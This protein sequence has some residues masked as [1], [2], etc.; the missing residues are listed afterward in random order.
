MQRLVAVVVAFIV[1]CAG[2]AQTQMMP[3]P[4]PTC[5]PGPIDQAS[6]SA[7]CAHGFSYDPAPV[8]YNSKETN[9]SQ[10][11]LGYKIKG[12]GQSCLPSKGEADACL[13]LLE[14]LPAQPAAKVVGFS[15]E[16][17]ECG[18]A[19]LPPKVSTVE[20]F[21]SN[22]WEASASFSEARTLKVGEVLNTLGVT[23]QCRRGGTD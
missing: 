13:T 20:E 23:Q 3:A 7:L 17:I 12:R 21:M 14:V 15:G 10:P 2:C 8:F 6:G 16:G 19:F 9:V 18:P 4:A 11:P 1:M 22:A 5:D